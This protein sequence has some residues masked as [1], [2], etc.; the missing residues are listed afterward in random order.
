MRFS[1][2]AQAAPAGG[3]AAGACLC[4]YVRPPSASVLPKNLVIFFLV[5]FYDVFYA[6]LLR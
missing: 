4:T 2:P 3:V 6:T 1:L 5:L